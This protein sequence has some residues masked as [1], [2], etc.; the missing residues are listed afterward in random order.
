MVDNGKVEIAIIDISGRT[1]FNQNIATSYAGKYTLDL[2]VQEMANG[3]YTV[4]MKT[5]STISMKKLV[6]R[7]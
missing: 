7:N 1:V 6:V 4:I 5:E 3:I 2:P